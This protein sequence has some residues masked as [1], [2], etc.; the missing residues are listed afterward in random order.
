MEERV[1]IAKIKIRDIKCL[2]LVEMELDEHGMFVIG[3]KNR[4]GKTA[5]LDAIAWTIG[6]DRFKPSSP[7]KDNQETYPSSIVE[8]SNGLVASRSGKNSTLKVVDA[9]GKKSGQTFLNS[10]IETFALDIPRFMASSDKEKAQS[11]LA[12][13]GKADELKAIDDEQKAAEETRL[14]I[15]RD[16][17]LQEGNASSYVLIP[18]TPEELISIAELSEQ[19]KVAEETNK[20]NGEFR[21]C[22]ERR[23]HRLQEIRG[24]LAALQQ[25]EAQL[26]NA[27]NSEMDKY[28]SLRDVDMS[29]ITRQIQE[30]EEINNKVRNNISYRS[31]QKQVAEVKA[32]HEAANAA[33]LAARQKK[34]DLLDNANLPLPG[35]GVDGEELT[36]NGKKWDCMSSAEQIMVAV[37]IVKELNP[38]CGFILVDKLEQI[39]SESL[40][41]FRAWI[42][43]MNLQ[44]IGTRVSTN[45][46]ECDIIIENGT[47]AINQNKQTGE[48]ACST[49][50]EQSK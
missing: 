16:L 42:K 44:L 29:L 38:K 49:E 25:E 47:I 5:I 18:D 2:D 28:R 7:K 43:A 39:D 46:S 9:N 45:P 50:R 32:K 36:F 10:F 21:A 48:Q 13:I 17:K 14:N 19:Y 6:G 22:F 1:S 34:I 3:G 26:V 15:G 20:K 4:Q 37:A 33:V 31:A 40:H 35:L 24:Q 8:L 30:A 11:L 41:S 23:Q 12:I 27:C